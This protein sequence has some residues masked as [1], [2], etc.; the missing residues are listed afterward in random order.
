MTFIVFAALMIVL[1]LAIVMVPLLKKP[2]GVSSMNEELPAAN[3]EIYRDQF[4]DLEDELA[5]GAISQREYDESRSELERRVL[6]ESRPEEFKD[7]AGGMAG[8]YTAILLVLLVPLLASGLWAATQRLGDFRLDGGKNEGVMDYNSGEMVSAPGEMHDMAKALEN[9]KAHLNKNPGDLQGWMMLGR[10]MLTLKNYQEAVS[11]FTRALQLAPGNPTIQVDLADALAMVQGKSMEG[12]PTELVMQALKADPSNWKALMLAGTAGFNKGDY[13]SAVIY[14]ERLLKTLSADDGMA[15]SVRA[16]I[17]EARRLGNIVGP[18]ADTDTQL[19]GTEPAMPL[20]KP[21]T[22]ESAA[23]KAQAAPTHFISGEVEISPE[24]YEKAAA[25]GRDTLYI[26]A[27]PADGSRTPIVQARTKVLGFPV[28]FTLDNTMRPLMNMGAADLS[29][30]PK[31][32]ITARLST[33]TGMMPAAG[34]IEGA[35]PEAVAVGAKDVKIIL[36]SQ[37]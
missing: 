31:V 12:R 24:L 4:K 14:W 20:M 21:K 2:Q 15:D 7:S 26:T 23:S 13:R 9:L 5:R 18:V 33:E 6:E 27:R 25:S 30:Y 8:A 3:L 1:L 17:E 10:T 37:K 28:H 19:K 29:E 22:A 35:T 36:K 11:A 32:I 34:D 16:S